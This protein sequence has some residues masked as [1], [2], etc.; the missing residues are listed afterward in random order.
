[1]VRCCNCSCRPVRLSRNAPAH[2]R[3]RRSDETR[4]QQQPGRLRPPCSFVRDECRLRC[5]QFRVILGGGHEGRI[6]PLESRAMR[7]SG[8]AARIEPFYV[9]EVGKAAAQLAREAAGTERP[10]IALNIGEPDF[11]AP[12]LVQEAALR[13]VRDGASQYTSALGL[14]AL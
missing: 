6:G 11:T 13:A 2:T 5:R 4:Q 3:Q 8:R 14:E 1:P 12:P 9:M 10:V 7:I